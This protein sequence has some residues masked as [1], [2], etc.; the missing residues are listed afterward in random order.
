MRGRLH[1]LISIDVSL[2]RESLFERLKRYIEVCERILEDPNVNY[3]TKLKAA[4]VLAQLAS[5]A[6]KLLTE[7]QLDDIERRLEELEE[8]VK[9]RA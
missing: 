1:I 3:E 6:G 5:R 9:D 4:T 2:E 8:E 7:I